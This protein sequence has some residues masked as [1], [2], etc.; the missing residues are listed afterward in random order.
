MTS[1]PERGDDETITVLSLPSCNRECK[2][3]FCSETMSSQA[4]PMPTATKAIAAMRQLRLPVQ[5]NSVDAYDTTLELATHMSVSAVTAKLKSLK[6]EDFSKRYVRDVSFLIVLVTLHGLKQV[7]LQLN[8]RELAIFETE[9]LRWGSLEAHETAKRVGRQPWEMVRYYYKWRNE[10]LAAENLAIREEIQNA[11]T[12]RQR[13]RLTL[14]HLLH[15]PADVPAKAKRE[16]NAKGKGKTPRYMPKGHKAVTGVQSGAAS[17]LGHQREATPESDA[18]GSVWEDDEL[19]EA[20]P[21]CSA[22][23]VKKDRKWWKAPRSQQGQYLCNHCGL[24]LLSQESICFATDCIVS[25]AL[26]IGSMACRYHTEHTWSVQRAKSAR[27]HRWMNP[28][29]KGRR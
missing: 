17:V 26:P 27:V 23:G 2:D 18:E 29:A 3:S 4:N 13:Q 5:G 6:A 10:K 28:A 24:V 7:V 12:E 25:S 21:A 8:P 11:K 1:V 16:A 22:C 20:K 14:S 9:L 19:K 15:E